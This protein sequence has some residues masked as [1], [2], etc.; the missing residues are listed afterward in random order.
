MHLTSGQPAAG[1]LNA[2]ALSVRDYFKFL[3]F[4]FSPPLAGQAR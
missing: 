2:T 4:M 3:A 1:K